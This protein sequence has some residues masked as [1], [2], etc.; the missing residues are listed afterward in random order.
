MK[1]ELGE[2]YSAV[3]IEDQQSGEIVGEKIEIHGSAALG[4]FQK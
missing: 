3:W 2:D 4:F 1:G